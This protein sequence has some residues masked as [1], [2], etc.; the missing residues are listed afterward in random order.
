MS[1]E[2]AAQARNIEWTELKWL[3]NREGKTLPFRA[4]FLQFDDDFQFLLE[5][6]EEGNV[7]LRH[8]GFFLEA[9]FGSSLVGR[10]FQTLFAQNEQV[11]FCQDMESLFAEPAKIYMKSIAN[12][13]EVQFGLFP[14]CDDYGPVNYALGAVS[15]EAVPDNNINSLEITDLERVSLR[16]TKKELKYGF[17][18][19]ASGFSG[20]P[21]AKFRLIEGGAS[22]TS[23]SRP[24][25]QVIHNVKREP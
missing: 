22:N 21:R 15:L 17:A 16:A 20:A 6:D 8:V 10:E 24:G 7:R 23:P 25:L 1:K 12:N 9:L 18:E 11:I 19:G 5:R 2:S 14:V 4:N 3:N 13:M